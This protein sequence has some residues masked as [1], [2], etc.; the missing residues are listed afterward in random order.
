MRRITVA[1]AAVNQAPLDWE[2]NAAR[3]VSAL[4]LAR[5]AAVTVL[6]L[7]ELAISGYGAEDMFLSPSTARRS[8]QALSS[9]LPHTRGLITGLGLPLIIDGDCYNAVAVVSDGQLRGFALKQHLARDGLYYEPRWFRAAKPGW[10]TPVLIGGQE[11]PAGD[12]AFEIRNSRG[13]FFRLGFEICEDAWASRRPG[14]RLASVGVHLIL[15]PSASHFA[16]GRYEVRKRFVQ[17]GSRAFSAAYLYANLLGNEA[18]RV[19]YDGSCLIAEGGNLVASGPRFSFNDVSLTTAAVDLD[20]SVV[21]R[22]RSGDAAVLEGVPPGSEGK[23]PTVVQSPLEWNVAH[24]PSALTPPAAWEV[25][26]LLREEEFAR[27][28]ALGLFD[29]LRKSGA[30]GFVVSLSGGADSSLVACLV[31]MMVGLSVNEL[32]LSQ[33]IQRMGLKTAAR[34]LE[35]LMPQLLCTVYQSTAQSSQTTRHAAQTLASSLGSQHYEW[36]VE[37]LVQGYRQRIEEATGTAL[38]WEHDDLT[39][40]NIQAR[41]RAPGVWMLANKRR[42]L[43]LATSNRS[44]IAVGYATMD[45]DTAGGYAPLGGID[46]AFI[47]HWLGVLEREGIA[48]MPPTPA[49]GEVNAQAPTAELRPAALHAGAPQ[50]DEEDLMPYEVLNRIERGMVAEGYDAEEIVRDLQEHFGTRYE[51][52]QFRQW[53]CRFLTLF[54]RNQWKRERYAP[55]LHVD[56]YNLDPRSYFRFPIL[57]GGFKEEVDALS[58]ASTAPAV[59]SLAKAKT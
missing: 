27:A 13:D 6:C 4:N 16:F 40:Q 9:L 14:S 44:E 46:K 7:P 48:L 30:L 3:L 54:S 52:S 21:R 53:V 51:I 55:A 33:V 29:Y 22:Q 15:N 26:R 17:E 58:R 57:S 43:L 35:E 49:L 56:Q 59:S 25:S 5:E 38:S 2:G 1:C 11:V 37:D 47:R 34:S 31:R 28:Q 32:G 10:S 20:L 41:A 36:S 23:A 45:G 24:A 42:A 18:G 12:L 50:T 8:L 19:V 39:L